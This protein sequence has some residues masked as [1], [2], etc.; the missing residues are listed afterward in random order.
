MPMRDTFIFFTRRYV[1]GAC[2]ALGTHSLTV[3]SS[4]NRQLAES[5][6]T[7]VLD[8]LIAAYPQ[9]LEYYRTRGIV[10]CFRDE[11]MFAIKDFT[12]AL[13]EAR[14]MRR[15]RAAHRNVALPTQ[16]KRKKK[17]LNEGHGNGLPSGTN[18][19]ANGSSVDGDISLASSDAPDPI[20][21]QLLFLRGAAYL[22][23]AIYL[24]ESAILRLEGINKTSAIVNGGE[25]RLC[26]LVGGRYGGVEIGNSDGPLG[27][28]HGPKSHAYRE[29]LAEEA[30]REEINGYLRKCIRDHERFLRH[31]DTTEGSS[32]IATSTSPAD[33][34]RQV[35]TALLLMEIMRP[36]HPN[37]AAHSAVMDSS[38]PATFTTYHPL[39]VESHFNILLCQLMLADLP[40]LLMTFTRAA[41]VVNGLDGYPIFIPPRSMAQAEF[42][43]VLERLAAGWNVGTQPHSLM[44]AATI[45]NRLAIGTAPSSPSSSLLELMSSSSGDTDSVHPIPSS[46][47]GMESTSHAPDCDTPFSSGQGRVDLAE[48]LDCARMLLVPVAARQK[49]RSSKAVTE[50]VPG[51]NKKP[52][53]INI[54]LHGPRVEVILAW[55]AAVHLVELGDTV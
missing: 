27:K 15:G 23:Q 7:Q 19:S 2:T 11:Y 50:R 26:Y 32:S 41:V 36:G 17:V 12:H 22:Q 55:L 29:V 38:H 54:P 31:F 45:A 43:E 40:T 48:A 47:S 13:K 34:A 18:I 53:N 46:S 24:I 1:L 6:T 8:E 44:R 28:A 20:E 10:H 42:M 39:I 16:T 9:R 35:E 14:S 52:L 21:L 51:G 33:L 49:A 3:E 4:A 5:T 37:P 25:L 30:F